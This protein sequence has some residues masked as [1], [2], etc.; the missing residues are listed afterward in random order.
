MSENTT[1]ST[2]HND[3]PDSWEINS[4]FVRSQVKEELDAVLDYMK[5]RY[6]PS[7]FTISHIPQKD[8]KYHYAVV[9]YNTPLIDLEPNTELEQ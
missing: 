7:I 2:Y 8:R 1:T 4:I 6:Q 5:R 3:V 9:L